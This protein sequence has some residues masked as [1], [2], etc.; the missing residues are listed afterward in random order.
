MGRCMNRAAALNLVGLR[1]KYT[2]DRDAL[3]DE[4]RLNAKLLGKVGG[5]TAHAFDISRSCDL[6]LHCGAKS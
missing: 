4:I 3:V 2:V 6:V 5:E 1:P